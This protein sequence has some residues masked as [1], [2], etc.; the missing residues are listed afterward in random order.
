MA[1]VERFHRTM[2]EILRLIV[3]PED[4]SQFEREVQR[5][6][7]WYNE[8]RPHMTLNGKTPN[9]VYHSRPP[10]NEQPRIEPRRDWSRN[11]SGARPPVHVDGKPGDPVIVEL[12]SIQVVDISRSYV[13]DALCE[14]CRVQTFRITAVP[15]THLEV[16]LFNSS[17]K[18]QLALGVVFSVSTTQLSPDEV[19]SRS[20]RTSLGHFRET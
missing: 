2:I 5:I 7:G 4:Q 1:V 20:R 18:D 13:L 6:V 19:Y 9:E 17:V 10:A 12:S 16:R 14:I 8:S 11:S 3:V 15:Q